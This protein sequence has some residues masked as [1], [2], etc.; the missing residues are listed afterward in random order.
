M[1]VLEELLKQIYPKEAGEIVE[2]LKP[3]LVPSKHL[4]EKNIEWYKN[5]QIYVT[6]AEVFSKENSLAALT[7]KLDHIKNLGCNAIHILPFLESPMIDAGFDVSDYLKVRDNLGGNNSF[8]KLLTSAKEKNTQVL[9]DIVSNHT[10]VQHEWFQKAVNGDEKYRNFYTHTASK[11]DFL[12]KFTNDKGVWAEYVLNG[13]QVKMRIVF[14]EQA[15]PIPH[16]EQAKDGYWYFHTFYPHQI[17]LDWHNPQ[18]FKEFSRI[19][20]HW[21]KKG[22]SFRLDAIPHIGK[23]VFVG[24]T[25]TTESTHVL[26]KSLHQVN[27]LTAPNSAFLVE[28][29]QPVEITKKYFGSSD[30]IESELA[31]NFH[32]NGAL[33]ASIV[34]KNPQHIWDAL[35]E[36]KKIPDWAQWIMFL[37]NHDQIMLDFIDEDTRLVLYEDLTAR[38]LSFSEGFGVAG[39]TAS[40][41]DNDEKQ[42]IMAHALLASISGSLAIYYGDEI[43][44]ENNHKYMEQQ[45]L[46]KKEDPRN[47]DVSHD[48]RDIN[49]GPFQQ[50][51]LNSEQGKVI[52]EGI[53]KILN[54]RSKIKDFST[55]IPEKIDTPYQHVF[56]ARF[57]LDGPDLEVYI[58]LSNQ[59]DKISLKNP[60]ET[61]LA[62]NDS[63]IQNQV[64][65]LSPHGV[66][67][68]ESYN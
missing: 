7:Q 52:L 11:P 28:A 36:T 24:E 44:Q 40:F 16:W 18:V 6:Y 61:L 39:R 60:G 56:A 5:S 50:E 27:K 35:D 68:V 22:A 53:S 54:T 30:H 25:D 20:I 15:G 38:G 10:S 26:V 49:R 2:E 37:R 9:M 47:K 31:Y 62:L 55:T 57:S 59:E 67:W 4:D 23:N 64:A 58:N 63:H 17:D 21:N 41:L 48:T 51:K 13:K 12:R 43:G 1:Q 46:L 42:V 3:E 14:P 19:L 29:V 65:H 8:E 45:T 32:L 66:V 34:G 33:W